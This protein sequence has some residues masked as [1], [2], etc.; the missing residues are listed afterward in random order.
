M[1]MTSKIGLFHEKGKQSLSRSSFKLNITM[2]KI[3]AVVTLQDKVSFV[4]IS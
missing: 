2:D 4:N 3:T 1:K